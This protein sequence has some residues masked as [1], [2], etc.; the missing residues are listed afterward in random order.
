[1]LILFDYGSRWK[2]FSVML[3]VRYSV[4]LDLD[5]ALACS[6]YFSHF[7]RLVSFTLDQVSSLIAMP[8]LLEARVSCICVFNT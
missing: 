3:I 4:Y 6:L 8:A 5:Y 1:M 2:H 7:E